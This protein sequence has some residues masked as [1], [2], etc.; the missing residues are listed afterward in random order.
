ML[1]MDYRIYYFGYPTIV[2]GYIDTNW[3]FDVDELY[4]MSGYIFTFD[5]AAV[6]WRICK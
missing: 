6:S 4:A 5:G 3:I 1:Q 2:E